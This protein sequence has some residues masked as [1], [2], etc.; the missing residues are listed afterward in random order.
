MSD[1]SRALALYKRSFARVG[2]NIAIRR[3]SGAGASRTH[4]D[5]TVRAR[6]TDYDPSELNG[7]VVQGDRKVICLVDTL[8]SILP[9]TTD[10][11]IVLRGSELT[12]VKADDS[13]RR[14]AGILIALELQ[15]RG[16]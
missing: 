7:D 8:T 5:T 11:K 4:A 9:V 10:D 6:V 3:F 14:V 1:A 2:E 16:A 12:I 15:A 13:T